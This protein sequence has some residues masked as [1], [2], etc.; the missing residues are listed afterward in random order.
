[1]NVKKLP[2]R[3]TLD[4]VLHNRSRVLELVDTFGMDI[5]EDV[6]GKEFKKLF[7]KWRSRDS[8]VTN[9]YFAEELCKG[10]NRYL[11]GNVGK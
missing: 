2:K 8:Y 7:D 5:P 6:D 3:I 11:L 4:D 10:L 1:M 9:Y